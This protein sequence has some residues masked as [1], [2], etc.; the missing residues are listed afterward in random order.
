MDHKLAIFLYS[1][2]LFFFLFFFCF[3]VVF[4][5]HLV[6]V[7]WSR[8]LDYGAI[9]I[10]RLHLLVLP[11][12]FFSILH[13]FF[14]RAFLLPFCSLV[15]LVPRSTSHLASWSNEH[16]LAQGVGQKKNRKQQMA[17]GWSP[18]NRNKCFCAL[19]C[20]PWAMGRVWAFSFVHCAI[21]LLLSFHSTP[22]HS[23]HAS[24]LLL[25]DAKKGGE[26][27][28]QSRKKQKI[29]DIVRVGNDPTDQQTSMDQSRPL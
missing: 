25:L 3:L 8:R 9:A 17:Q 28:Y 1:L 27:Y 12:I 22:L 4:V 24:F 7:A 18:S 6:V 26:Q 21:F 23:T 16:T 20:A 10:Y 15:F 29:N 14:D 19:K 2:S 5:L 11:S 13:S